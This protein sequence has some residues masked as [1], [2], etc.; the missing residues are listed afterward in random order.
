MS[1]TRLNLDARL[2][3]MEILSATSDQA[4][5]SLSRAEALAIRNVTEN[6]PRLPLELRG[7]H[8]IL[9]GLATQFGDFIDGMAGILPTTGRPTDAKPPGVA[10]RDE[11]SDFV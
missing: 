11:F 8:Q 10:T 6:A 3:T 1:R 9:E 4:V 7:P 2:P 5:V